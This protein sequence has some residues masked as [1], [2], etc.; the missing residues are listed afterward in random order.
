[1]EYRRQHAVTRHMAKAATTLTDIPL[2]VHQPFP[3]R[4]T[5]K[6][7]FSDE[8]ALETLT[9]ALFEGSALII[10]LRGKILHYSVIAGVTPKRLILFDSDGLRW[11]E[12]RSLTLTQRLGDRRHSAPL[13][14]ILTVTGEGKA[15]RR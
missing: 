14:P 15:A 11:V 8:I 3:T 10:E 2:T 13:S 7:A 6:K 12:L 5:H 1:M 9:D 4:A